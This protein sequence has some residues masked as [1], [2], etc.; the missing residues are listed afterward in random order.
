MEQTYSAES[1]NPHPQQVLTLFW[2]KTKQRVDEGPATEEVQ[3][4]WGPGAVGWG[5]GRRASPGVSV[6]EMSVQTPEI[7]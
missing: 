4:C 5:N 2:G 6:S 7:S 3:K 1:E